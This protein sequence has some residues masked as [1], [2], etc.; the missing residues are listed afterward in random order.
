MGH[1]NSLR[2][3]VMFLDGMTE[4]SVRELNIPTGADAA[5]VVLWDRLHLNSMALALQVCH[6]CTSWTSRQQQVCPHLCSA[7][8]QLSL[9]LMSP[10]RGRRWQRV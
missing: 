8:R 10:S 6:W 1:S 7:H 3:L 4:D 9:L 5:A 2:A